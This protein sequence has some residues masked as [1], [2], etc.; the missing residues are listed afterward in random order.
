MTGA[1]TQRT[2]DLHLR[3]LRSGVSWTTRQP[4][5]GFRQAATDARILSAARKLIASAGLEFKLNSVAR[6]AGVSRVTVFRRFE[7]KRGLVE[8]VFRR[9]TDEAFRDI[10]AESAL[11]PTQLEAAREVMRRVFQ[12]SVTNPI[13]RRLTTEAPQLMQEWGEEGRQFDLARIVRE[14]LRRFLDE[15]RKEAG[16]SRAPG[17]TTL[18]ADAFQHCVSGYVFHPDTLDGP[19][20]PDKLADLTASTFVA[21]ALDESIRVSP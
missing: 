5:L 14:G 19:G 16:L 6:E 12:A 13:L 21:A 9:E 7:S 11:Q 17:H 4:T 1:S 20:S 3:R 8:A 2:R 10:S 18:V 15:A